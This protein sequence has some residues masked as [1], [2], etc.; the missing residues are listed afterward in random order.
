MVSVIHLCFHRDLQ[1]RQQLWLHAAICWSNVKNAFTQWLWFSYAT[2]QGRTEPDMVAMERLLFETMPWNW[3]RPKFKDL[4]FK[5]HCTP[6][7]LFMVCQCAMYL[8]ERIH[9]QIK[10][11]LLVCFWFVCML[12]AH[13]Y[14]WDII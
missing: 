14:F 10:C 8:H 6:W 4:R 1:P 11:V 13:W 12:Q 2:T 9:K 5:W 3:T 7:C